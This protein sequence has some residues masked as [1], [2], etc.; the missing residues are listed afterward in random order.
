MEFQYCGANCI[1]LITKN[2]TFIIDDN[3]KTWGLKSVTKAD[4]IALFT[5]LPNSQPEARLVISDP[6]EYEVSGV[7]IFGVAARGHMDL[8]G[9]KSATIYKFQYD[10]MK[11]CVLGHV[12]PG[13]SEDQ[14]EEIGLV[15][16]L[17]VPVGGSGYTLDA[18]GA[19][20]LIKKIEPKIIIPTHYADKSVKYEVPQA[21]L[22]DALKGLAMEPKETLAKFKP[23]P[24]DFSDAAQLIVLERQ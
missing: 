5:Q 11:V 23:K 21:E 6:G 3:L 10:D 17:F 14:L 4:D 8:E 13:L 12:Y 9:V 19:L 16:I 2:A 24:A 7:S 1:K 20:S 15:D 18:V 22:D